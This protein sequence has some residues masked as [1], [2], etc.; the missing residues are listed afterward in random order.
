METLRLERY[1]YKYF[2]PE[3]RADAIRSFIRP[4]AALDPYAARTRER[5]YTIHN[6]YLDTPG[7]DLYCAC[8][9][10][11]PDRFKLR[12]R[13]YDEQALGP[14]YVEVKRKIRNV[15]VKDRARVS[16]E[17]FRAVVRGDRVSVPEGP[18]FPALAAVRD[19]VS[20]R[21]VVPTLCARYTRE[22]YESLFGDYARLT[23][24][25]A[26][27]YQPARSVDLP[28]EP[29]AW[30]Y[31]DA[32]PVTGGIRRA[33]VLELKFTRDF[34]RWMSDLVAEFDLERTGFSKYVSSILHR[35]DRSHGGMDVDRISTI[36][37]I[38]KG[39]PASAFSVPLPEA[40]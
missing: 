24:D 11:D 38:V 18:S 21:G 33:L 9:S 13:W 20:L 6:I 27:C 39:R 37:G 14:F 4:Y 22:P 23:L 7:L 25:R 28:E 3:D 35:L 36:G 40:P 26:M 2:V 19:Q 5:R 8:V 17:E 34:P 32:A 29:R 31:V 16:L 30:T 12:I 15:V 1:E 10:G